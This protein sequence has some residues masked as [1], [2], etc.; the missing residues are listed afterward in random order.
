[1][2]HVGLSGGVEQG[3]EW[4]RFGIEI[5]WDRYVKLFLEEQSLIVVYNPCTRPVTPEE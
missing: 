5:E 1:V 3:L 2:V 4:N